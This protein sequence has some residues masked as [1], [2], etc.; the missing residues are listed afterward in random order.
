[1]FF[2]PSFL[3]LNLLHL[4]VC[5]VQAPAQAQGLPFKMLGNGPSSTTGKHMHEHAQTYNRHVFLF[6]AA[7]CLVNV[8]V[9][10]GS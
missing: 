7:T 8:C 4:L 5:I 2:L 10:K 3:E 1:M 9:T 6:Q